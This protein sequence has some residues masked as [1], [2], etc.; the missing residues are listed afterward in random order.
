[1]EWN[2]ESVF[3][4]PEVPFMRSAA[5]NREAGR[6]DLVLANAHSTRNGAGGPSG[7]VALEVQAVYFR[8]R[9]WCPTS[10]HLLMMMEKN[11]RLRP[12]TAGLIGARQARRG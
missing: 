8:A 2:Q 5:N 11:R 3:V 12:L 9:E 4:A 1:M 7:W 10:R 6:I